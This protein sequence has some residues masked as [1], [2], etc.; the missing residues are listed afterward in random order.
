VHPEAA[1]GAVQVTVAVVEPVAVAF[2][3]VGT[4][5]SAEQTL[6]ATVI[7]SLALGVDWF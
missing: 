6:L 1:A 7:S 2:T 5:G 3:P 4:P